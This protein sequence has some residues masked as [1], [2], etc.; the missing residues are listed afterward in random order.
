MLTH[1]SIRASLPSENKTINVKLRKTIRLI[2]L[3]EKGVFCDGEDELGASLGAAHVHEIAVLVLLA[4]RD[5][6]AIQ[7]STTLQR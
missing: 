6:F 5:H 3:N 4:K 1:F 2:D 7:H